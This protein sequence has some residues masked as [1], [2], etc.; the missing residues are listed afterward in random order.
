MPVAKLTDALTKVYKNEVRMAVQGP[1]MPNERRTFEFDLLKP[2]DSI[3]PDVGVLMRSN[4]P[5]G[6]LRPVREQTLQR[7]TT[8]IAQAAAGNGSSVHDIF[9]DAPVG[10]RVVQG[11]M[12]IGQFMG[13]SDMEQMQVVNLGWDRVCKKKAYNQLAREMF[14]PTSVT[15]A[16]SGPPVPSGAIP[17]A[18]NGMVA[19]YV[20]QAKVP[21]AFTGLGVGFRVD[22]SGSNIAGTIDRILKEG[23]T[24]QLKNRYLMFSIK[25]WEVQGTTVDL[26]TNAPRVWRT[27]DDLFNESAVCVSRNFYGATAFPLR[28]STDEAL[29]WA[30]DVGGL[31]GYD[32]EDHQVRLG[33]QWRPGEKAFKRIAPS[34]LIGYARF[35]K[36]GAPPEG[37]WRFKIPT[38]TTWTFLNAYANPGSYNQ[39]SREAQIRSYVTN[40]LTA[41]SGPDRTISGAFD[42][43]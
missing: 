15:I 2:I 19:G 9:K 32:T 11:N 22:G 23:M 41:W 5:N 8:V 13:L 37:G 10:T 20:N 42:F 26:D 17:A 40:Q 6:G 24:T 4:G 29:L 25:G 31:I 14:E 34:R 38:G 18:G 27:K 36:L 12:T 7:L 43:A 1:L 21:D 16:P 28:E 33:R 39:N 30:V 35:N 3:N